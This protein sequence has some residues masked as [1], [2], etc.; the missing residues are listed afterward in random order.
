MIISSLQESSILQSLR[1][2][3]IEDMIYLI[4]VKELAEHAVFDPTFQTQP[5]F[6]DLDQDP[7]MVCPLP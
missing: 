4:H 7:P 3:V 1:V 2:M 5:F 6:V